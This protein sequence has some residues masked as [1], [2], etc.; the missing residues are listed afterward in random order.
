MAML[1]DRG[2]TT[3][4]HEAIMKWLYDEDELPP[5]HV[6][7]IDFDDN[8][9]NVFEN[10]YPVMNEHGFKGTVFS[11]S[12]LA[13]GD[14][15]DMQGYPWMNWQQLNK[16]VQAGWTIGAHTASHLEMAQLFNGANGLDGPKR[17]LDELV[18]CNKTIEKELGFK[19]VC[20]AYPSG[21][22]SKEVESYVVRYYKTARLWYG[23][24]HLELNTFKTNPYRLVGVNVSMNMS[25]TMLARLLDMCV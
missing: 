20:F 10:A 6:V 5:G 17:A 19:P 12:R 1:A 11:V 2:F 16:L 21:D 18:S 23:D 3:V 7:C 25:D 8:R 9:L 22:W 14:L 13:G 4:T 15:P 24:D